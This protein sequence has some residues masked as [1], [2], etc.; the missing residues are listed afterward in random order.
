MTNR[1]LYAELTARCLSIYNKVN[2]ISALSSTGLESGLHAFSRV[3]SSM[4]VICHNGEIAQYRSLDPELFSCKEKFLELFSYLMSSACGSLSEYRGQDSMNFSVKELMLALELTHEKFPESTVARWK[5]LLSEVRSSKEFYSHAER[6]TNRNVYI[7]G[8]EQLREK[9]G[10]AGVEAFIDSCWERQR[11]HFNQRG[12]YLDN[13]STDRAHNPILYD[14]TTR[15][16]LKLVI[17]GGYHGKYYD[18]INEVLRKGAKASLSTQSAAFEIPAGGRSNQFLFNEA[19]LAADF[20]FE[21]LHYAAVGDRLSAGMFKQAARL[22]ASVSLRWLERGKHIKN[23]FSDQTIGA[24]SYGCYDKYM[25][26][27]SSFL[28]L[29]YLF[30][31][32]SIH[33]ADCP[34]LIGGQYFSEDEN[35]HIITA[36]TSGYSIEIITDPDRHYDSAGLCRLHRAGVPTELALSHSFTKTPKYRLPP[37]IVAADLSID[38]PSVSSRGV[39]ADATLTE[40]SMLAISFEVCYRELGISEKY[41]LSSEGLFIEIH[42][43][44][45]GIE[46]AVPLL[47]HGDGDT[48]ISVCEH[49]AAV[50]YHG[51]VYKVCSEGRF[52][53]D[54]RTYSNRNGLYH[55]ARIKTDTD[56][57]TVQLSLKGESE[58]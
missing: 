11:E 10:L 40:A 56:T 49:S 18:E 43:K 47:A 7:M 25:A 50:E 52:T 44:V 53:F 5:E 32:D 28:A 36:N 24:E 21:A 4:A 58:K 55:V 39:G 6:T 33:E 38:L 30:A 16:Q 3:I 35:F 23:F 54:K 22:A 41:R 17:F 8:G 12:M 19:L 57:L 46:F 14:L 42:S 1:D 20:E 13:Y 31:D 34:A 48:E 45:P 2:P 29:A 37:D 26:T 15:V 9:H 51:C 27:L